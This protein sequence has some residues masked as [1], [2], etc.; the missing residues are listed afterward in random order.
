MFKRFIERYQLW[1]EGKI[2]EREGSN[3]LMWF[4]ALAVFGLA[5]AG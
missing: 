2:G 4:A 1:R 3:P 5:M